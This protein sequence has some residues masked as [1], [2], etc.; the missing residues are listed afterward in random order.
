MFGSR[1]KNHILFL[2]TEI[3]QLTANLISERE[4]ADKIEAE[5]AQLNNKLNQA[6]IHSAL[7]SGLSTPFDYFSDSTKLL[8]NS[9]ASMAQSMMSQASHTLHAANSTAQSKDMVEKLTLR[10]QELIGRADQSSVAIS[11]L[12]ERSGKIN[13]IVQLIT[14]VTGQTNLLALNAAIEAARAGEQGRGFAVVADEVRNLAERTTA[15][16]AEISQLI[17]DVQAETLALRHIAEVDPDEMTSIQREGDDAFGH[18]EKL[19]QITNELT[20]TLSAVALRSFVETAKTDHLVY[21][22]E[23]YRV[24][25]GLSDKKSDDFASHTTCRLGKWY[26]EGDGKQC[27]S[28]LPGYSETESPHKKVHQHGKQAVDAFHAGNINR[29]IEQMIEM[30]KASMDVFTNLERI[31]N[32]GENNHHFITHNHL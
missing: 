5:N 9:L 32:A 8:Q 14:E 1:T 30:E 26:Y 6:N 10:I 16:T 7:F 22:Q 21:K 2:N 29:A 3:A 27:C 31:A 12:N 11:R 4:R 24:F 18:I 13:G 15:S 19:L 20:T 25:L 23:I 28:T 17:N